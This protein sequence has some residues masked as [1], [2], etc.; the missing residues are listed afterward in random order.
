MKFQIFYEVGK[1]DFCFDAEQEK[2]RSK[3]AKTP[4]QTLS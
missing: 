1:L 4:K 3:E 2:T